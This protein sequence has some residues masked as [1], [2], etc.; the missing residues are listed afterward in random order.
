MTTENDSIDVREFEERKLPSGLNVLTILS[1]IGC[2]LQLGG[3]IYQFATAKT[4]YD[5]RDA[6]YAK[7]TSPDMPSAARKMVGDPEV[8]MNTLVKN[9]ENKIPIM[10]LALVSVALCFYGIMLMRKLKKQGYM[11]YII[12]ELLPF[13]SLFL[14]VGTFAMHG[15]GFMI[16][17][18]FT[19]LFVILY[20]VNRKGLVD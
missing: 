5:N 13:L 9:Y 10:L 6:T 1:I 11:F 19:L 14:F 4:T 16:A 7:M 17:V 18:A 8:F 12:G 3:A 20:T 15:I 2:V